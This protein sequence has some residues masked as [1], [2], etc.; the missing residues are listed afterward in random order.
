MAEVRKMD[1]FI[2]HSDISTL[3]HCLHV[4]YVSFLICFLF[5]WDFRCAARGGLLHDLFLYDWHDKS[6][7]GYLHGFTHPRK[8]LMNARI[9]VSDLNSKEEDIILNHMWPLTVYRL[10]RHRETFIV[11]TADKFCTVLEVLKIKNGL[12]SEI[13]SLI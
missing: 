8:A 11:S 1:G 9:C 2:Q 13:D 10:P 4:S 3:R 6:A 5:R 7:R 12:F